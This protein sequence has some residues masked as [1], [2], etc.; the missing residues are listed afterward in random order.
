MKFGDLFKKENDG[1]D[2]EMATMEIIE[3]SDRIM[4]KGIAS[5]MRLDAIQNM[6]SDDIEMMRDCS[7]LWSMSKDYTMKVA[8]I[9][10]QI[11]EIQKEQKTIKKQ[12]EE[13]QA[14]LREI[15]SKREKREA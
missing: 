3:K 15:A 14:L 11:P 5:S 2:L 8:V 12:L 1:K 9:L 4:K 7:A 10:N 13:C 6:D